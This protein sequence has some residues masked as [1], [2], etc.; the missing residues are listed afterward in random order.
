MSTY[1]E[2]LYNEFGENIKHL[3]SNL[4]D[5]Q[6]IIEAISTNG[7]TQHL[8][9]VYFD[10]LRDIIGNYR[11]TLQDCDNLL[12]DNAKFRWR[13]D[14]IHNIIWNYTVASDIRDLKD[15]LTYLNIKILTMLKTWIWE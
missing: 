3:A 5:L 4:S 7:S 13:G 9:S 14:F 11:T 1:I 12:R 10:S 15:R 8:D 2:L 6:K